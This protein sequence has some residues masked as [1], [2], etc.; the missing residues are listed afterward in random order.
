MENFKLYLKHLID[1][2]SFEQL[3]LKIRVQ[4]D[5]KMNEKEMKRLMLI[6]LNQ[7]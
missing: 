7:V 4:E 1:D 6:Q 2:T 3:I 5:N